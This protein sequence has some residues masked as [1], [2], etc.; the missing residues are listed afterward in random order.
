MEL[1]D[2]MHSLRWHQLITPLDLSQN[3]HLSGQQNNIAFLGFCCDEGV[4][5]NK[6]RLGAQQGPDAIRQAMVDLP[7]HFD[8]DHTVIF[9][10]GNVICP[11]RNL[12]TAQELLGQKTH[13]LLQHGFIPV[14]LGGGHEISYGHY[15]GLHQHLKAHPEAKFGILNIDSHF[16]LNS[17][18]KD[19]NNETSFRQIADLRKNHNKDFNYF[20]IGIQQMSNSLASYNY[21]KNYKTQFLSSED[22][23]ESRLPEV[24]QQ[25]N[26]WLEDKDWVYLSLDL[27]AISATYAP[28]VSTPTPLGMDP[29]IVEK[30]IKQV[31]YS[32]KVLSIDI[33]ELCPI[34]DQNG[35]TSKLAASFLFEIVQA[36]SSVRPQ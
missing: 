7:V 18:S 26:S 22:V 32:G 4:Q 34:N 23:R 13:H 12:E 33:A 28:G 3:L 21:A 19:P 10:A 16:N 5:R 8:T 14:L 35:V 25:L 9:D 2:R 17:Y 15:L 20:C 36:I 29:Y 31:I 11:N 27:D 1:H 24:K 30:I 6:G